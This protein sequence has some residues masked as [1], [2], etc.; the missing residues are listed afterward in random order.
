MVKKITG[1]EWYL[2]K[3]L[4]IAIAQSVLGILIALAAANP[5]MKLA[6]AIVIVKSAID[7][8]VRLNTNRAIN[9]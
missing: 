8:L 9:V 3:T 4:W 6:G 7:I 2:S 1:K 5:E